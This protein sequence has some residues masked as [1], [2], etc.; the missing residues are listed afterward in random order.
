MPKSFFRHTGHH[1]CR[2]EAED[3]FER[4]PSEIYYGKKPKAPEE[5]NFGLCLFFGFNV[6]STYGA[7]S[8]LSSFTV[9]LAVLDST[10]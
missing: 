10:E 5:V 2:L 1:H 7:W 8:D 6:W 9:P 4:M 3:N